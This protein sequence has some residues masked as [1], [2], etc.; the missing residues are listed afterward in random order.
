M[1]VKKKGNAGENRFAKWLSL[2]GVDNVKRNSGSGSGLAKSDVH[3]S[4]GVNFEIKTVKAL[5]LKKAF[6][7][8]ERDASMTH[9]KPYVVVHFDGMPEDTWIVCMSSDD[10][11]ELYLR[12]QEPKSPETASQ[13]LKWAIRTAITALKKV[14][15][16]LGGE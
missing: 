9:T 8:S 12:T 11:A 4:L 16:L 1:N 6:E 3:N 14:I 2:K 10:W 15:K 13:E 7:Q 5:N